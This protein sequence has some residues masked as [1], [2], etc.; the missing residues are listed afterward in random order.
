MAAWAEGYSCFSSTASSQVE[1]S[2][3]NVIDSSSKKLGSSSR[4]NWKV[5]PDPDQFVFLKPRGLS[6]VSSAHFW[7]SREG[8]G[9]SPNR[10]CRLRKKACR[11]PAALTRTCFFGKSDGSWSVPTDWKQ[12]ALSQPFSAFEKYPASL[13]WTP[14]LQPEDRDR[15]GPGLVLTPPSAVTA[16]PCEGRVPLA[17]RSTPSSACFISPRFHTMRSG[18]ELCLQSPPS[19]P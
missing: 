19:F 7:F 16:G 3:L 15:A 10:M 2:S 8:L 14:G 17:W 9:M 5:L 6:D 13:A 18:P 12:C 4:K 1:V 11:G